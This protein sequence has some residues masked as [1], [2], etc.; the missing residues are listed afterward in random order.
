MRCPQFHCHIWNWH[1]NLNDSVRPYMQKHTCSKKVSP[2]LWNRG[3][4]QIANV[5]VSY[6]KAIN[7]ILKMKKMGTLTGLIKSHDIP[8]TWLFFFSSGETVN[9]PQPCK[10]GY[11]CPL[12]TPSPD[13]FPC[14]EGT[15][16]P[17]ANLSRADQCTNCTQGYYC[18]GKLSP[19][20]TLSQ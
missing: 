5:G 12:Q 7:S 2:H 3:L 4:T 1:K 9:P 10:P 13:R 16:S 20:D 11:Y 15:F 8:L 18:L 19:M 14:P 17:A 6:R